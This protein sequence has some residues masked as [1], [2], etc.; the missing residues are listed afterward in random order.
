VLLRAHGGEL[1]M[2]DEVVFATHS[3]DTLRMLSDAS[4]EERAALSAIRYQP[5]QAV[6]HADAALMPRS[7]R[8]WSSWN[9]VEAKGPRPDRIDLTYWMNSLQPIP[10]DDPLFVTL[11]SN[12]PIRDDLIH[13]VTTFRHPVFDVGALAAQQAIRAMNG[14]RN[15][16]FCGAWMRNG[17]H[18]D[19]LVSALDVVEAMRAARREGQ[20]AA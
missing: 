2:F 11:N 9:Y 17:F 15:T 16:W 12:Q 19:G 20:L 8:A 13:D 5:N 1:E 7:P 14:S 18:E 3:D 10:K 4:A 6:L